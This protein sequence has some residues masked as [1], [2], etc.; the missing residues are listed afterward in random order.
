MKTKILNIISLVGHALILAYGLLVAI[1]C[2]LGL[3]DL[4]G[5]SSAED[6]NV[7]TAIGAAFGAIMLTMLFIL[8]IVYTIIALMPF[9]M[10]LIRTL[11]GKRGFDV[12]CIIFAALLLIINIILVFS[13]IGSTLNGFSIAAALVN[14]ACLILN[15]ITLSRS[16]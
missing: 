13:T 2:H 10:K 12:A 5:A 6:A 1:S 3:Q 8:A 16:A 14:T 15:V 9:L 4:R 11:S 7:G